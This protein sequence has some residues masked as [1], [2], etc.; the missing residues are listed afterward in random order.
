MPPLSVRILY[1]LLVVY[2]RVDSS[3]LAFV[4][5]IMGVSLYPLDVEDPVPGVDLAVEDA[6]ADGTEAVAGRIV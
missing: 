1:V 3:V 5:E 2:H 6:V 4:S